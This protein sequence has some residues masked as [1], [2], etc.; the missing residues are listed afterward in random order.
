M[1]VLKLPSSEAARTI[2][3]KSVLNEG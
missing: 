1:A 2:S 3:T